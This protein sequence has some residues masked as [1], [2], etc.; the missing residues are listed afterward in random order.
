MC[1]VYC[2]ILCLAVSTLDYIRQLVYSQMWLIQLPTRK[3]NLLACLNRKEKISD[4]DEE[5]LD[6]ACNL[7]DKEAVVD[8]LENVSDFECGLTWL[9]SQ[10]KS[11]IEKLKELGKLT[12]KEAPIAA[13]TLQKYIASDVTAQLG[14]PMAWLRCL[15]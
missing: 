11:V 1:C 2:E 6:N 15:G 14:P 5:W 9:T 13:F 3:D 4:E 8:L 12:H 10:Q 7:V